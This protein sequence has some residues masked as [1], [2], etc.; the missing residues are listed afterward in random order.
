MPDPIKAKGND[1]VNYE[2]GGHR[3]RQAQPRN[4]GKHTGAT[5]MN[6]RKHLRPTAIALL[7]SGGLMALNPS[8]ADESKSATPTEEKKDV[9]LLAYWKFDE[10]G[11]NDVCVDASGNGYKATPITPIKRGAG[12]V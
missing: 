1:C 2:K 8:A 7:A 3:K 12:G 6:T 9:G 4:T 10:P 5:T 11:E